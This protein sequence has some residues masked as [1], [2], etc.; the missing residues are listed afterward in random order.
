MVEET[1]AKLR[2]APNGRR[3]LALGLL[4]A[5]IMGAFLGVVL[6]GG[7][8][9]APVPGVVTP[10]PYTPGIGPSPVLTMNA[11]WVNES[12]ATPLGYTY[13][14]G[15]ALSSGT[16]AATPNP[17]D[18]MPYT[19]SVNDISPTEQS[20]IVAPGVLQGNTAAHN[21]TTINCAGHVTKGCDQWW[22]TENWH[23]ANDTT[24]G[25]L[26]LS[27]TT[28]TVTGLPQISFTMT[29]NKTGAQYSASADAMG[30]SI[31]VSSL[32]VNPA[33]DWITMEISVDFT[34]AGKQCSVTFAPTPVS[35]GNGNY[36]VV[37]PYVQTSQPSAS[38]G[39][40]ATGC[41]Y[42]SCA[43][44]T[45]FSFVAGAS[46]INATGNDS[47]TGYDMSHI[48]ITANTYGTY[49]DGQGAAGTGGSSEYISVPL[50]SLQNVIATGAPSSFT[51]LT[52]GLATI[53][54]ECP[55]V[56]VGCV[57]N[58][59]SPYTLYGNLTGFSINTTS[60]TPLVP[61]TTIN[62]GNTTTG[63]AWTAGVTNYT[64]IVKSNYAG[65]NAKIPDAF[66]L[67]ALAPT[68][69]ASGWV[70]STDS[71]YPA[72]QADINMPS[73]ALPSSDVAITLPS[74]NNTLPAWSANYN[75]SWGA[76]LPK[77]YNMATV[78]G[79]N[80][81]VVDPLTLAA[82]EYLNVTEEINNS[83]WHTT[84]LT[85]GYTGYTA[86]AWQLYEVS[87][88][89]N[90]LSTGQVATVNASHVFGKKALEC[91]NT[92]NGVAP[93]NGIAH[94]GALPAVKI[95]AG[96]GG[97]T[98]FSLLYR[99]QLDKAQFCTL[100]PTASGCY[101][102]PPPPP[103][104][105]SSPP[106]MSVS[107]TEIVAA[108]LVVGALAALGW[109][110]SDRRAIADAKLASKAARAGIRNRRGVSSLRPKRQDE[111]DAAG[112]GTVAVAFVLLMAAAYGLMTYG[113]LGF[114]LNETEAAGLALV[115]V[116]FMALGV[117]VFDKTRT[118]V[119]SAHGE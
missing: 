91:A 115:F 97:I 27:S 99:L 119:K 110:W 12:F 84:Y 3:A 108:V 8:Y 83:N 9:A 22:N 42:S 20:A 87:C 104:V 35:G 5:L 107:G 37:F 11:S 2:H 40:F 33:Y 70:H 14:N 34:G 105:T 81:E 82:S 1:S 114:S 69:G 68:W 76:L 67:S 48:P 117:I 43:A 4:T 39:P 16:L 89:A 26:N 92:V 44:T 29:A 49:L 71:T 102:V 88:V 101:T 45:D 38:L 21:Y 32:G 62:A 74:A 109:V 55:T 57:V 66:N 116:V 59:A 58:P 77:A 95:T 63:K 46:A 47:P 96:L 90:P 60:S 13:V 94:Q 61:G 118:P 100:Y 78:P 53:V 23:V 24:R 25:F 54:S 75:V 106:T 112:I 10:T 72:Y 73:S 36:C 7:A 113:A 79:T 51:N 18:P 85:G 111:H 65:S 30:I 41:A 93:A 31:P 103:P 15:N 17:W 52:V 6:P 80:L 50:S 56:K 86:K 98:E 64:E 19:V 28:S